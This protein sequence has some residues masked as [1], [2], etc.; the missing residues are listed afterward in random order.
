MGVI[1]LTQTAIT[2]ETWNPAGASRPVPLSTRTAATEVGASPR[3]Y[4]AGR[5]VEFETQNV[6]VQ[7][8]AEQRSCLPAKQGRVL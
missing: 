5:N 4:A 2:L 6:V 1:E 8:G 7:A 3:Q